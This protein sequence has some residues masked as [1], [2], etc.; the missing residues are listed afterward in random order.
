[1][2]P[3]LA[4]RIA[5]TLGALLVYRIGSN[6]PL[7]GIDL[8][9]WGTMFRSQQSGLLG[10]LNALTGG[11]IARLSVCALGIMP[12]IT[13]AIIVQLMSFF[14]PAL[15]TWRHAG[16]RGRRKIDRAT[17]ALT[18]FFTAFQAYGIAVALESVPD[19]ASEPGIAF[20]LITIVTLS[21][22]SLFLVW[23]ADQISTRGIGNGIALILCAGIVPALPQSIVTALELNRLGVLSEKLVAGCA[24]LGLALVVLVVTME[25]AQRREP[26]VFS[27]PRCAPAFLSFKLNG[28]GIIPALFAPWLLGLPLVIMAWFAPD[29]VEIGRSFSHGTPLYLLCQ[30]IIIVFF[31][32]LYTAFVADPAAAAAGLQLL[33]GRVSRV[34][35]GEA[36]A[37][38]LDR[39]LSR[40]TLSGAAY[41][42]T[43]CLIPELLIS[44]AEVPFYLGGTSILVL[45]CTV[46]DV[47]A[48]VR[49][50][51]QMRLGG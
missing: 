31:V 7:P 17:L 15:R 26:V 27:R 48:E 4:R 34:P 49:G 18:V 2:N 6:I 23:L 32:Y 9:L 25:R 38:R 50:L 3:E 10:T 35:S 12:F 44:W 42:V 40:I 30:A 20:R 29:P 36:T 39:V 45:V 28:A 11:G 51:S 46:L 1:M 5:F 24:L 13:A 47:E 21:G 43:V 14:A 19:I 41:L 8:A 37:D 16:E 33:G 22:G